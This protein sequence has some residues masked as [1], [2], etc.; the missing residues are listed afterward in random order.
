MLT[1][2]VPM[3][4]D[5]VRLLQ[6]RAREGVTMALYV[7]LSLL[8]VQVALPPDAGAEELPNPALTVALS[9]VGLVAAHLFAFRLSARF[10]GRGQAAADAPGLLAVQLAGGG[11]ATIMAALPLVVLDPDLGILVSEFLL[12][13]FVVLV[14]YWTA[15]SVPVG[16]TRAL[17]Y[18]GLITVITLA[19]VGIKNLTPH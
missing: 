13:G 16:R 9:G 10:V 11:L 3:H 8:A 1:D 7:S 6:E 4:A 14:G 18:V 17:A 15:R 19:I 12:L 5:R 2:E